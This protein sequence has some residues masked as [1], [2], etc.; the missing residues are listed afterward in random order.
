MTSLLNTLQVLPDYV[1][2]GPELV[3][4]PMVCT[5]GEK[6]RCTGVARPPQ[7]TAYGVS[8][9]IPPEALLFMDGC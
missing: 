2:E 3:Q 7:S 4:S 1:P 5:A 6:V 9:A 8:P